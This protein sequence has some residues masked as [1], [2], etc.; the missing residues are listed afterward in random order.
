MTPAERVA[1]GV[2]VSAKMIAGIRRSSELHEISEAFAVAEARTSSRAEELAE[3][4]PPASLECQRGSASPFPT[5]CNRMSCDS[6]RKS[7]ARF[8]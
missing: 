3:N 7:C 8:V 1:V 6:A 4:L 5:K 2:I